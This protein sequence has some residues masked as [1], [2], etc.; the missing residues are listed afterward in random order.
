MRVAVHLRRLLREFGLEL[1]QQLG[2]HLVGH[3][4]RPQAGADADH[5]TERRKPHGRLRRN[6]L[7]LLTTLPRP[8]L[9]V[10]ARTCPDLSRPTVVHQAWG[11]SARGCRRG[12][13]PSR[14]GPRTARRSGRPRTPTSA[15]AL[16][17]S[18]TVWRTTASRMVSSAVTPGAVVTNEGSFTPGLLLFSAP[19]SGASLVPLPAV[20]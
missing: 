10:I 16:G 4:E 13:R 2:E 11:P 12:A 15:R 20:W 17:A 3:R 5:L 9:A 7:H 8:L 1:T 19:G 6:L 14:C 18:T